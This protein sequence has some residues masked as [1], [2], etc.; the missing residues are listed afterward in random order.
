[1][2]FSGMKRQPDMKNS[3]VPGHKYQK[4]LL[5]K[6][7]EAY[8]TK[9]LTLSKFI[10]TQYRSDFFARSRQLA[11]TLNCAFTFDNNGILVH[12]ATMYE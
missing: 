4:K 10:I 5:S 1:M 9:I 7:S 6:N 3:V 2:V 8:D 12:I 11:E